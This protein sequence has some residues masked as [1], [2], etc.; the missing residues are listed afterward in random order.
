M[1]NRLD[2]ARSL[3]QYCAEHPHAADSAE[4]I[5]GWLASELNPVSDADL[6][7]VLSR[8]EQEG[9]LARRTLA[10]GTSIYFSTAGRWS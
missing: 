10:D 1:P 7:E 5:R 9:V 8:L 3:R 4:G 2:V 6:H